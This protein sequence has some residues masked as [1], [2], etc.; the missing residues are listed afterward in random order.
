MSAENEIHE[1]EYTREYY[2]RSLGLLGTHVPE[3]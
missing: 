3:H 1:N 2:K